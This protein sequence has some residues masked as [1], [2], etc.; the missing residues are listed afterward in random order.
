MGAYQVL[1]RSRHGLKTHNFQKQAI[2]PPRGALLLEYRSVLQGIKK[3]PSWRKFNFVPMKIVPP[4]KT[5]C[6]KGEILLLRLAN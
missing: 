5:W 6:S 4:S 1:T 2:K 3:R